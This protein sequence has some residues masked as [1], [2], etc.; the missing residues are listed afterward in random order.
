[1]SP[2]SAML[3]LP[4]LHSHQA[5]SHPRNPNQGAPA[6]SVFTGFLSGKLS[7][8]GR[9]KAEAAVESAGGSGS[10]PPASTSSAAARFRE[11]LELSCWSS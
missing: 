11:A 5:Q 10:E 6:R 8:S 1:M 3:T 2:T 7:I 9:P 4:L